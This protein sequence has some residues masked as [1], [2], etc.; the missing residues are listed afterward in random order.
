MPR[1]AKL[2]E[3]LRPRARIRCGDYPQALA[4]SATE[5]WLAI[6]TLGGEIIVVERTQGVIVSR[7]NAHPV[8]LLS[9]VAEPDGDG[10]T[11][12]GQD[13]RIV[14]WDVG[15]GTAREEVATGRGW[16]NAV[17]WDPSGRYCAAAAAKS[18]WW[19]D[20]RAD[21]WGAAEVP[22][23][24]T[25]ANLAWSPDGTWLATVSYGGAWLWN[26]GEGQPA[27]R[28]EWQGSS[29]VAAWSPGGRFLATGD[30]DKSV[31]FWRVETAQDSRMWG[32]PSKVLA[33]AWDREG[34]FLATGGGP[35]VCVWDCSEPGP[36]GREPTLCSA[37]TAKVTALAWNHL[38]DLLAAGYA[39]GR[40][41]F[42]QPNRSVFPILDLPGDAPVTGL[43]WAPDFQTLAVRRES[44]DVDLL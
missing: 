44:G 40:V 28:F 23:P 27:K 39:D 30:Q 18:L 37:G 8:G 5:P 1:V 22:H 17:A 9:L 7:W 16:V 10:I 14:R 31:H 26:P 36:E 34:R 33:I 29:L 3:S 32:Y 4:W 12:G 38:H 41:V 19:R 6:G 43:D 15:A 21:G 25:V 24:A 20:V 42:W 13:G 35:D 11:S 2:A